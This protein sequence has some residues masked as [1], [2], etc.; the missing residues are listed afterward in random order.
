MSKDT[1]HD[2]VMQGSFFAHRALM[3]DTEMLDTVAGNIDSFSEEQI[4]KFRRWYEFYW[5]M[6][7]A[8]HQAEDDILFLEVE[9]KLNQ[10]SETIEGM[11]VEHNRL[12][13][14]ID[15][16]KRL[17]GEAEREVN[18]VEKLKS[19]L[20]N[21]TA[22]LLQ[23]F[24]SHIA[25]EEKFIYERMTS[26][27]TPAEQRRIEERVKRKA[28]MTYLTY[29]IPWLHDSLSADEKKKLDLSLPWTIKLLNRFFW[30]EKYNR[31]AAPVK[32]LAKMQFQN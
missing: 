27:F 6:M 12:R 31:I 1:K 10:P 5:K 25:K 7:E 23:L 3:R 19:K 30:K 28:P 26:H 24:S 18:S 32:G 9:K 20:S 16:I 14:L 17:I 15:E 8:H 29:M 21:Y 13:F 11:E 4:S 2:F 22:E